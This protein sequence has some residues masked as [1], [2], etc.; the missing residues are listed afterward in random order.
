MMRARRPIAF[1]SRRGQAVIEFL[2]SILMVL[3]LV[4]MMFEAA[5]M[6]YTYNVLG[7]AAKEGVRYAI[8]HGCDVATPSGTCGAG[9]GGDPGG[10]NVQS[11]VT[12]YAAYSFHDISGMTVSVTYPD[13]AANAAD[14]VRVTVSYPYRPLINFGWPAIEVNAVAEGR[15]VY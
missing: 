14:R 8:V 5:L 3:L 4:F 12:Q 11:V 2:L 10:A 15:I 1:S 7:D 13:G 6:V 9:G